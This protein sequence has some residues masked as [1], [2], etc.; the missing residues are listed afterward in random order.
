MTTIFGA[1]ILF[2]ILVTFHE[3][4]HYSVARF[5]KIK[6]LKFSIGFGPDIFTWKNKDNVRFSLSS[7]PFGGYVAFH[8][9]H[10]VE[11]Y[12]KLSETEKKYVLAN[13]PAPE[14]MLVTLA[15]PI[16]NFI[17]SFV[18]FSFVAL[19]IPKQ[20]DVLTAKF[21]K[22]DGE[23]YFKVLSVNERSIKNV[24]DFEIS[25]LNLSGFTGNIVFNVYDYSSGSYKTFQEEVKD[26][27]FSDEQ[28]PSAHFSIE[29]FNDYSP[30]IG[31]IAQGS[32]AEEY[33][34]KDGDKINALQN[35]KQKSLEIERD[36]E[37]SF[38]SLP[39][40]GQEEFYGIALSPESNNFIDSLRYGWDQTLFW[41][42]NTF[43]FLAKMIT[44]NLGVENLS[45]RV[46]IAKVAG[47]SLSS[48]LIPFLL[49]TAIL[50][51][52]LGAFNLLPLPMLDGGQFLFILFEEVIGTPINM[53]LKVALFNLSYMFILA[54]FIFVVYNDL[55]RIF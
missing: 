15:G 9:P 34:L 55:M 6:I 14:K 32:I 4:G 10:D 50:S 26:L 5:F 40:I 2:L 29:A 27:A 24:Q 1:I 36:G 19:F 44:G 3:Y 39:S 25:L 42:V 31:T 17:L 28:A 7:I 48:G 8:D 12:K 20:P 46:G 37:I 41:I 23:Q 51:I 52:S 47:D 35:K 16:F 18:I 49:L 38:L 33:G 45:G 43:K 11:N 53:K 22:I 13:R 21:N 30:I 54:L